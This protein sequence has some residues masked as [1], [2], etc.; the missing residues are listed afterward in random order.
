MVLDNGQFTIMG[1]M[2]HH[3]DPEPQ[4]L[5]CNHFILVSAVKGRCLWVQQSR[6][7]W[8]HI[9]WWMDGWMDGPRSWKLTGNPSVQSFYWSRGQI[10]HCCLP[11]GSDTCRS[12]DKQWSS[13]DM[14][15]L[16]HR[17][18]WLLKSE[19]VS[20]QACSHGPRLLLDR[21]DFAEW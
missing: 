21:K 18:L 20:D 6:Q 15:Q 11:F 13:H 19:C 10:S 4:I 12:P 3:I 14:A 7:T 8:G 2:Q 16:P 9:D 1:Q 17:F 5:K